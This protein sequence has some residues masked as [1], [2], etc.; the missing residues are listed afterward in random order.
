[1]AMNDPTQV[2]QQPIPLPVQQSGQS[3]A[4]PATKPKITTVTQTTSTQSGGY[5]QLVG[6]IVQ[7]S[8][9]VLI[10]YLVVMSIGYGNHLAETWVA[11]VI[12]VIFAHNSLPPSQWGSGSGPANS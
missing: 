12:A 10:A 9:I 8:E 7:V 5:G 3:P 11:P 4:D 1:M 2:P 6:L